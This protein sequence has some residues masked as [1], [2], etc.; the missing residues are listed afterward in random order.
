MKHLPLLLL[1]AACGGSPT[2]ATSTTSSAPP[3]EGTPPTTSSSDAP[4]I[5]RSPG[6]EGGIVIL[7]PRMK[8]PALAPIA[9]QI[10]QR[11]ADIAKRALPGRPIDI[12]PSPERV[13]TRSG[14]KAIAIGAG[15]LQSGGEACAV[16]AFVSQPGPSDQIIVPWVGDMQLKAPVAA[17]RE[18]PESQVQVKDYARCTTIVDGL[19]AREKDVE[20]AIKLAAGI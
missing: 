12:R 9:A 18:P 3:V 5:S 4:E 10:Q 8:D 7:W 17:F 15:L 13:C 1:L 6:V 14:C 11:L 19:A 16:I 20:A 2:P